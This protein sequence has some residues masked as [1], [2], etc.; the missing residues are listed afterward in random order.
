M[1]HCYYDMISI[2]I[3]YNLYQYIYYVKYDFLL[4]QC[5]SHVLKFNLLFQLTE[6]KLFLTLFFD[7]TGFEPRTSGYA[8]LYPNHYTTEG[9]NR[10]LSHYKYDI[11]YRCKVLYMLTLVEHLS[12]L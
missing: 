2:Y 3:Q 8:V 5:Q 9:F 1:L 7:S 11:G 12:L 6:A 10:A 4:A